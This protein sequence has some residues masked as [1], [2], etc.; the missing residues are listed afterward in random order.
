MISLKFT[1]RELIITILALLVAS[2]YFYFSS[3]RRLISN[4]SYMKW[5]ILNS[6]E[7]EF[8]S[9]KILLPEY[10]WVSSSEENEAILQRVLLDEKD[11]DIYVTISKRVIPEKYLLSPKKKLVV[12]DTISLLDKHEKINI[13]GVEGYFI[14]YT[15]M[16]NN[17]KTNYNISSWIFPKLSLAIT[18]LD[19]HKDHKEIYMELINNVRFK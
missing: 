5:R 7:I 19:L 8:N 18:A 6:N 17:G 1:K 12:T 10:W 2:F 11:N 14:N 13:D 9:A 4:L 3:D 15:K 16:N